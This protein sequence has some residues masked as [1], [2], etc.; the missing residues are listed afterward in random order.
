MNTVIRD[1]G[2]SGS[3]LESVLAAP[4]FALLHRPGA[5]GADTVE[6]LLGEVT[7]VAALADLPTRGTAVRAGHE[8][9]AVIP[10]RQIAERGFDCVDDGEPIRI[11]TIDAQHTIDMKRLLEDLPDDP[12][13]LLNAD[14]DIDDQEYAQIVRRVLETEIGGGEGANFVIKRTFIATIPGFSVRAALSIY[15]RLL[16]AEHGVYWTFLVHLG[17]RTFIGATPECHVNLCAGTVMMNPISGTYRYPPSGPTLSDTLRFLSD[18]KET[19]E[20]FMVVDEELKMMAHMCIRGGRVRGPFLKSMARVAHTEYLIDGTSARGVSDILRETLFAPTVVGSPLEN[21]C[22]VLARH[23]R[24]GRG[25][26]SGALALIGHDASGRPTMDSAI[27]IRTADVDQNGTV[28]IGVGAT[29]VRHSDPAT[30]AAETRAKAAGLLAAI[31]GVTAATPTPPVGERI[32]FASHPDVHRLLMGRN[33]ALAQF[34]L[35]QRGRSEPAPLDG[36]RLLV[37][38]AEDSFTAMLRI[39]LA[40]LG[41]EV[42]TRRFDEPTDHREFDLMLLGPGPGDP[43]EIGHPKIAALRAIGTDA[44]RAGKPLIAVCLGHQVLCGILGLPIVRRTLPNQ[45]RQYVVNLFG[46]RRRVGF[47]NTF[48]A[49]SAVGEFTSPVAG[50]RVAVSR[51]HDTGE[52]YATRGPGFRSMQFHPESVLSPD[53]IEIL[54]D[55]LCDILPAHAV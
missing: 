33:A 27:M 9:L 1:S 49:V 20:L 47:Y 3:A 46:R 21:A 48:A 42:T 52:V 15:R 26:Y 4:A 8:L 30:E 31:R 13:A 14:F 51:D 40:A 19:E 41:L 11:L 5:T 37:I 25:Y 45:G 32:T 2:R 34:W 7:T 44:L 50:G 36:R 29:L 28:R 53:G 38:D 23:E 54:A 39:Q 22:R 17:D 16:L 18:Q 10:Y 35:R 24:T 12:I 43:R 6:A 55:A